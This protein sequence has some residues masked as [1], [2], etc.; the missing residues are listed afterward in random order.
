[1]DDLIGIVECAR[2]G[3]GHLMT[4]VK[5][6]CKRKEVMKKMYGILEHFEMWDFNVLLANGVTSLFQTKTD[7]MYGEG[8]ILFD[9]AFYINTG[10]N[11][12]FIFTDLKLKKA[13]RTQVERKSKVKI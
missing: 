1:M 4:L 3:P 11:A 2:L 10:P 6:R 5:R 7:E 13:T 9:W 12:P 8:S